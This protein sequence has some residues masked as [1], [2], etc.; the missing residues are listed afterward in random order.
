ML[1]ALIST[2][3]PADLRPTLSHA[4]LPAV[5][6]QGPDGS[7]A[8]P[9]GVLAYAPTAAATATSILVA[10]LPGLRSVA[11]NKTGATVRTEHQ[12]IVSARLDGSNFRSL[13]SDAATAQTP[14]QSVLGP[15]LYGLRAAAKIQ[16]G[17]LSKNLSA[18]YVAR[19]ASAATDLDTSHFSGAA[20]QPVAS[21]KDALQ[22]VA[23]FSRPRN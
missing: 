3:E 4:P 17:T 8:T 1:A 5:I 13:T 16:P 12:P 21:A 20:V 19:F 11:L 23:S 10:P 18:N 7:K 2:S 14:T 22:Q 6:T 9:V 15:S